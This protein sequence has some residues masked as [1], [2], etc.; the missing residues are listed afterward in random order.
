MLLLVKLQASGNFTKSNTP[1]VLFTFLKLYKW[2]QIEQSITYSNTQFFRYSDFQ[3]TS[4][5]KEA[6]LSKIKGAA[7]E[8]EVKMRQEV[9]KVVKQNEELELA[10][11]R[12]LW[13]KEDI[14]KEKQFEIQRLVE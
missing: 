2:Y 3:R 7:N 6:I 11:K 13:E 9:K 10:L 1:W 5:E 4:N 14:L 12:A 8:M